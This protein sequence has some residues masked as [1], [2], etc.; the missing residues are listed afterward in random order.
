MANAITP[1]VAL[2][3][4]IAAFGRIAVSK[5]ITGDFARDTDHVASRRSETFGEGESRSAC[6]ILDRIWVFSCVK[7]HTQRLNNQSLNFLDRMRLRAES[8]PQ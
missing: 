1:T 8:H 4:V 2:M 3:P 7:R 6:N 5:N